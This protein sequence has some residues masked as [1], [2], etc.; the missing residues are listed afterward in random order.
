MRRSALGAAPVCSFEMEALLE[1]RTHGLD[2]VLDSEWL[3]WVTSLLRTAASKQV[4]ARARKD[5]RTRACTA[6]A[7]RAA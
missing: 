3:N 2:A 6:L 7:W 4:H 1:M 5:E